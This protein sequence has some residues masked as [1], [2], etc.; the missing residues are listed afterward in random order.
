M[1]ASAART[2]GER[3]S[4]SE[5]TATASIP[6]SRHARMMRRAISPRF[7]TSTRLISVMRR[8]AFS[9]PTHRHLGRHLERGERLAQRARHPGGPGVRRE[10]GIGPGVVGVETH[11]QRGKHEVARRHG[12][13]PPPGAP[14]PP[15]RARRPP[16]PRAP[17]PAPPPPPAHAHPAPL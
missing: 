15:Q 9:S 8:P 4:T 7:A 17:P 11:P 10:R 6:T 14:P 16:P 3:R 2:W 12:G 1:A 5:Y 13:A